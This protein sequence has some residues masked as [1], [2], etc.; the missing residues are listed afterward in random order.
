[1]DI[2]PTEIRRTG[3]DAISITWSDNVRS[4]I[5]SQKL[6]ANCPCAEC[7]M[8]RGED[9]HSTPLTPK[10]NLLS[11][12]DHTKEES[13]SLESIWGVGQYAIGIKWGDGHDS[14][15]FTFLYLREL[16]TKK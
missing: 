4:S 15:I 3:T 13:L 6:R 10:K 11:I 14:G 16:A 1:M 2:T 9:T 8:K 12:V 7:K 5:S